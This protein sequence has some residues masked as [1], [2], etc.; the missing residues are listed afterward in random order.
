MMIAMIALMSFVTVTSAATTTSDVIAALKDSKIADTY[1]TQAESYLSSV[2]VTSEQ[3]D[4]II[5]RI[6][7]VKEIVGDRAKLSELSSTESEKV[8][9]E[10]TAA[11]EVMDLTVTYQ[12]NGHHVL[13]VKDASNNVVLSATNTNIIKQTGFDY[14]V[15]LYGM[16]ALVLA[17][18]S[19]FAARKFLAARG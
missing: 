4:A 8:L 14:S 10:F 19:A 13:T 12:N 16:I 3:A 18:V 7:N 11:A 5:A 15:V 17:V 2:T 9:A 6:D 1:I